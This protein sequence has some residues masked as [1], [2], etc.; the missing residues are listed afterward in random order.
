M[1]EYVCDECTNAKRGTEIYCLCKQ[2][3]DEARFYIGCEQCPDWFHGRCVGILQSEAT[4]IE[5][6]E[7]PRCAPKSKINTSNLRQL[8]TQDLENVKKLFRQIQSSKHSQPFKT[9]V[10]K[11]A[12]RKYY[13]VVKEPMDL[14]TV[15][16]K[17][18]QYNTLAEFLGDITRIVENCR[19]YNPP[20]TLI[21]RTAENLELFV[22]HKLGALREKL[23]AK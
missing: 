3:Y 19:Y 1:S 14:E 17:L 21:S 10:D 6:Y 8:R 9:A 20:G 13:A 2:P 4:S 12:N 22:A 5:M 18:D 16:T 7:C 15:E 23:L 11:K